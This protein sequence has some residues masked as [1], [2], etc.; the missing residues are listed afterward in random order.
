MRL[1]GR[2]SFAIALGFVGMLALATTG[3]ADGHHHS[4]HKA[5]G[6]VNHWDGDGGG[7]TFGLGDVN[8]TYV[9]SFQGNIGN[10]VWV[11]GNGLLIADGQGNITGSSE[12]LND[13]AGD[14][15][16]GTINGTYTVNGDG[17]G[18]L[19]VTFTPAATGTVGN[20]ATVNETAAIVIVSEDHVSV[21][22]TN[23]G[24]AVLGN[25]VR[26]HQPE[27]GDGGGD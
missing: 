22:Q 25:L 27:G 16:P 20:C 17:T 18:G 2:S 3:M 11:V 15:C 5:R 13:S 14:F 26:Q 6:S 4:N 9:N 21:V 1:M 24:M 12:L 7:G 19:N 23:T 8:G 10:G